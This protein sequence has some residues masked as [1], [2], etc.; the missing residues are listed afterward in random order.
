MSLINYLIHL[1]T[2]VYLSRQAERKNS[3]KHQLIYIEKNRI[4][5][6]FLKAKRVENKGISRKVT[7]KSCRSSRNNKMEMRS[8]VTMLIKDKSY[9]YR[10]KQANWSSSLRNA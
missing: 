6:L 4:I 3:K 2:T 5:K 7:L 9:V 10:N 1:S 8:N